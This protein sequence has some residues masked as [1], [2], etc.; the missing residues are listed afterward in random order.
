MEQ[1][2][3]TAEQAKAVQLSKGQPVYLVDDSG[4]E[5]SV[6]IVR[7]E[8]LQALAGDEFD[9]ADTYAAQEKALASVWGDDPQLDEYTDQ[10]GSPIE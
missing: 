10:D 8:L 4:Q 9:I 7:I 2:K 5:A 3:I 6:A 1:A